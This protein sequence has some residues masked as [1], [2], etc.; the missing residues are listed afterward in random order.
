[1]GR[2]VPICGDRKISKNYPADH[3]L[4]ISSNLTRSCL[5]YLIIMPASTKLIFFVDIPYVAKSGSN[6]AMNLSV[7]TQDSFQ[8]R[9]MEEWP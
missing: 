6:K 7:V 3:Q 9:E 2:L 8:I 4:D 5:N 1:M